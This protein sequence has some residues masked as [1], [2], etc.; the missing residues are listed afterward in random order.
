MRTVCPHC[1][2]Q[3]KVDRERRCY[4]CHRHLPEIDRRI[5]ENRGLRMTDALADYVAIR[6]LALPESGIEE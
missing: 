1:G 4:T 5:A 6:P 2:H 3:T